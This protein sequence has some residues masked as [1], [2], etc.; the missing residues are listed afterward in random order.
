MRIVVLLACILY[1]VLLTLLLLVPNPA[2]WVGLREVPTFTWGKFGIHLTAF[3]I[4]GVLVNATR[5]PKRPCWSLVAF[6]V[7][8]AVTTESLQLL[9]PHRTPRVIDGIE[10]I[11][12]ISLG[13]SIYWLIVRLMQPLLQVNLAAGLIRHSAQESAAGD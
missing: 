4:L 2:A 6:L 9:V 13:S 10:N 12:G 8:Y 7:L 1:W 11:L 3:T 5:W